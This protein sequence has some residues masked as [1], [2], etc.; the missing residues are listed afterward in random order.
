MI[1]VKTDWCFESIHIC[2]IG[3][4]MIDAF[5]WYRYLAQILSRLKP[6]SSAHKNAIHMGFSMK[7]RLI[8][9][10]GCANFSSDTIWLVWNGLTGDTTTIWWLSNSKF[11]IGSS[12]KRLFPVVRKL[13]NV[14][15]IVGNRQMRPF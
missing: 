6:T 5:G 1:Q 8:E 9:R 12:R 7:N 13:K 2:C 3:C 10:L 4:T 11:V 15:H 14:L